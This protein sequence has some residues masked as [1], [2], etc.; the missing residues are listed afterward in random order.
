M[1]HLIGAH[2]VLNAPAI[3][4]CDVENVIAE[5]QLIALLVERE[6]RFPAIFVLIPNAPFSSEIPTNLS[7]GRIIVVKS[8]KPN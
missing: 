5:S 3:L 7:D 6:K 2:I 8:V 4:L 1:I